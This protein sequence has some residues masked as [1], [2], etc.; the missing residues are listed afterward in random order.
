[1]PRQF[2]SGRTSFARL[3]SPG[4][5]CRGSPNSSTGIGLLHF[6][7]AMAAM[8]AEEFIERVLVGS[9]RVR[10][11]W[12]GPA[13]R[14]GHARRKGDIAMLRAFGARHGIRGARVAVDGRLG[15]RISSSRIR[16]ALAGGGFDEAADLL[17][18]RFTMGGHVVAVSS[19]GASSAIPT[20]NLRV[21]WGR[22]RSRGICAVRVTGADSSAGLRWRAS[23]RA[24][25]VGGVE[26][27]LEAHL[28]D[29][30][31]DLYG[32]KLEVDFVAKLRDEARFPKP[33][34]DGGADPPG[35]RRGACDTFL[36]PFRPI[37]REP[38]TTSP[39]STCPT[40]RSR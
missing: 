34:R 23:A 36:I 3:S 39:P 13:F 4:E 40:P 2:F 24:P 12:V 27:L 8:S 17:G 7:A 25:T 22:P 26:P 37:P 14:F 15:E 9:A 1:V 5:K 35:R 6:D 28:F 11:L 21:P 16:K 18:R 29:F 10:E 30:D 31:G 20:A 38:T 19:W 32:Q 33:G